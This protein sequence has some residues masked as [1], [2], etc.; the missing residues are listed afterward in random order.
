M[1]ENVSTI[2]VINIQH[3]KMI[4]SDPLRKISFININCEFSSSTS[5]VN[6]LLILQRV[7]LISVQLTQTNGSS[8]LRLSSVFF[9]ANF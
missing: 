6:M 1:S 3:S 4:L 7:S 2:G 8:L 9:F 5:L